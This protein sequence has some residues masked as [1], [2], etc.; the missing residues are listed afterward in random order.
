[1]LPRLRRAAAQRA[2]EAPPAGEDLAERILVPYPMESVIALEI[3]DFPP[4]DTVA[5]LWQDVAVGT[6]PMRLQDVGS[7]GCWAILTR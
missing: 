3:S 6:V 4:P 1:M 2:G 5:G 7:W